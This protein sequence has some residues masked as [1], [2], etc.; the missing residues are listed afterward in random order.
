MPLIPFAS[1]EDEH[2]SLAML[3][4]WLGPF[5]SLFEKGVQKLGFVIVKKFSYIDDD[6][7]VDTGLVLQKNHRKTRLWLR[8]ALDDFIYVDREENPVRIDPALFDK[9]SGNQ[10]LR[11][12][13]KDRLELLRIVSECRSINEVRK[14]VVDLDD[15]FERIK[16]FR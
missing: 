16:I 10:K 8:N 11:E 3:G 1:K 7:R 12:L 13:I 2:L 6:G 14:R 4:R 15:K 9:K 5:L